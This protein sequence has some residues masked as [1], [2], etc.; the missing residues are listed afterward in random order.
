MGSDYDVAD[1][2][3]QG[4]LREYSK[5]GEIRNFTNES[6]KLIVEVPSFSIDQFPV[7]NIRYRACVE[8]GVCEQ[9][10]SASPELPVDYTSN[11]LYGDNPVYGV[12]WNNAMTYCSWTGKRLPTEAEW[13]K[14][15]RGTDGRVY[16]WGNVW[17]ESDVTPL[18]SPIGHHSNAASPYQVQDMLKAGGEWTSDLIQYYPGNSTSSYGAYEHSI[19]RSSWR[20]V[21]GLSSHSDLFHWVTVRFGVN[22]AAQGNIGFRCVRGQMPSPT[23]ESMLV[24]I[25]VPATLQPV[26]QVD[27]GYMAYIPAG[28]FIMGHTESYTNSRG[29]NERA[30]AMPAHVVD[31]SAFYIDRYKVTY[32]DYAKFI[33]EL[34][35]H[36]LTCSGF[37]CVAVRH[38]SDPP[39]SA[40]RHILL[41]DGQY[42]VDPGFEGFPVD[43]V[44]W[45]GAE[46]YCTWQ[47][48]RLPSEAEWEKA[49][50]GTDGRLYPWGNNWDPQA[51]AN[52]LHPYA[53][54]SQPLNL[55]PYGVYDMLGDRTE[56]VADWYA[57]DYY[58]YSPVH[59]PIGPLEGERRVQRA[60]GGRING[61]PGR[62]DIWPDSY[63]GSF[64]CAYSPNSH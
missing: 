23:L 47:G 5:S 50:R 41:K 52:L 58:A 49:A 43:H 33:N 64:R 2:R 19:D 42:Q 31:L 53:I 21:R 17:E 3:T 61:L 32:S 11:S 35:G 44:T 12:T 45:Y 7:T 38:P 24:R 27:L 54:G 25:E 26:K 63:F 20:V 60:L 51:T 1:Q 13:E 46:A 40:D 9:I 8:A 16:P 34:G 48:K 39:S 22:P 36:A 62:V 28:T 55:S 14:A 57:P 15:A 29:I 6:P 4:W 59:N 56:W 10:E 18:L 30:D 37:N